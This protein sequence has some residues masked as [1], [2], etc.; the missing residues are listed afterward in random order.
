M[1]TPITRRDALRLSLVTATGVALGG[2]LA[3]CS[4]PSGSGAGGE[5]GSGGILR[6]ALTDSGQGEVLDPALVKYSSEIIYCGQIYDSLTRSDANFQ[7]QPSLAT[8]WEANDDGTEWT[9]HLREGVVFHDG[10]PFTANDV[11]FSVT[12]ILDPALGSQSYARLAPSMD[13]EGVTV[14]DDHTITF[15]LKRP[16]SLLPNALSER[17]CKIVKDGTEEFTVETAVGTGPFKI[18]SWT[19]GQQWELAKNEDYWEAG[20]P[21]LDGVKAVVLAEQATKLQSLRSGQFDIV[22]AI[23]F[24]SAA[25]VEGDEKVALVSMENRSCWTFAM[26]TRMAPFNED[27][28]IAQAMKLAQDRDLM[29]QTAFLGFGTTTADVPVASESPFYP[30]SLDGSQNIEK[31]KELLAEAGYPDGIDIELNTT[32][33]SAGMLDIATTLQE[34]VKPA[35]IRI[36]IKQHSGAAY[37]DNAYRKTAM[38]QDYINARHPVDMLTLFYVSDADLNYTGIQ[39]AELDALVAEVLATPDEEARTPIIQQAME[40]VASE[41]SYAMPAFSSATWATGT[42]VNGLELSNTDMAVFKEIRLS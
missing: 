16:D 3:S 24:T 15:T 20:L 41:F 12:R 25:Q 36:Q 14:V 8:D 2:S 21:Y 18:T 4:S 11:A 32:A 30:S 40:R 7:V 26:D 6:F 33:E 19:P 34:V 5:G 9:F 31:A 35:G 17:S 42:N 27:P 13:P 23:G 38:F 22:D 28:R 29:V 39:D 37:W 1:K 10:S